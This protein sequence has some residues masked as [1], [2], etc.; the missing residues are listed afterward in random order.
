MSHSL[1]ASGGVGAILDRIVHQ[2]A[3]RASQ[4]DRT[5]ADRD[6]TCSGERNGLV[7][8]CRI[9]GELQEVWPRCSKRKLE[10]TGIRRSTSR[11]VIGLSVR[12]E[13]LRVIRIGYAGGLSDANRM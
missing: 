12:P 10:R 8:V 3:D 6:V 13:G 5:T 9:V 7:D 1:A 2:V 11:F 4:G